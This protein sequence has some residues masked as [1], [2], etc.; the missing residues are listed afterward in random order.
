MAFIDKLGN[1][2]EK[3]NRP[4]MDLIYGEEDICGIT[5][6]KQLVPGTKANLI[7][8]SFEKFTILSPGEFI[9]NRRTSRNGER[10]SLGYNTTNRDWILTEDYCH[11]RV[12]DTKKNILNPDYLYLFFSDPEFDRYVRFNSWGSA[13]EFFNWEEMVEVPIPI[14]PI[15]VQTELV[16]KSAELS[17]RISVLSEAISTLQRISQE[18]FQNSFANKPSNGTLGEI[19]IENPK[20]LIQVGEA[21]TNG[22]E[23]PFFTSGDS[24][25][26]WHR[27]LVSGRNCFLNTGGSAGLK[28][29]IGD[30]AYSTDTWCICGTGGLS[31]YLYLFLDSILPELDLKY[32][33]GTGLQHLQKPLLKEREVYIPSKSEVDVFNCT[34]QPLLTLANDMT[35][36]RQFLQRL[37]TCLL[38]L[39]IRGAND[40]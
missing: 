8:R 21:K 39:A 4:N 9:F 22:G 12:K 35:I 16:K 24:I 3:L 23:Y 15:I 28:Y 2:I 25:L 17:K 29:Y 31:D 5:N 26:K 40:D 10:I 37:Q 14:L 19:I 33:Q 13:T 11:F 20:S 6:T 7:G 36:E 32:F 18:V 27:P 1:Y 38:P 34:I 30:A